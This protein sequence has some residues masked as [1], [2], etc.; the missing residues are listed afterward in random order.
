MSYMHITYVFEKLLKEEIRKKEKEKNPH[1]GA[2][3]TGR[4]TARQTSFA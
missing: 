4:A 3:S 1:G 2:G